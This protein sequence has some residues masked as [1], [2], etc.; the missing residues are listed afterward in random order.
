MIISFSSITDKAIEPLRMQLAE[1]DQG[2]KDQL[3][4]IAATKAN[5]MKND[6]KIEKMLRTIAK[7]WSAPKPNFDTRN[8]FP[9]QL[10]VLV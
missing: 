5:I 1:A 3:D 6:Q 9:H 8:V 4:L 2:I 10:I 7:S